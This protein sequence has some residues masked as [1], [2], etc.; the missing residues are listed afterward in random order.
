MYIC[1]CAYVSMYILIY[2]YIP[3]FRPVHPAL[4]SQAVEA[5]LCRGELE[6]DG[7]VSHAALPSDAAYLPAS[8]STQPN[9]SLLPTP[10]ENL[11]AGHN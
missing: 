4:H 9:T 2:T 10:V 1:T 3:L 5:V 6:F 8:Q 7:Q 11:P